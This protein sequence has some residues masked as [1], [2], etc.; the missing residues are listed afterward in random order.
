MS[1]VLCFY[2]WLRNVLSKVTLNF[3]VKCCLFPDVRIGWHLSAWELRPS[4]SLCS[5]ALVQ[6][7]NKQEYCICDSWLMYGVALTTDK[8]VFLQHF[9]VWAVL[10]SRVSCAGLSSTVTD[11][12]GGVDRHGVFLPHSHPDGVGYRG[13]QGA[14]FTVFCNCPWDDSF[15]HLPHP[16]DKHLAVTIT[17]FRE[18]DLIVGNQ[19]LWFPCQLLRTCQNSPSYFS[20]GHSVLSE[21]GNS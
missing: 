7:Q 16:G 9:P 4:L 10:L 5:Q 8:V 19:A 3:R 11:R 6:R 17:C 20:P 1:L 15:N 21:R 2:R 13:R 12:S 14:F 18:E